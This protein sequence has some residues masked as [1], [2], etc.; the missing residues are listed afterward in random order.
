M[1]VIKSKWR[2]LAVITASAI[3]SIA[4]FSVGVINYSQYQQAHRIKYL[5][6]AEQ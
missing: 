3:L 4:I 6:S 2:P 1:Q 5:P